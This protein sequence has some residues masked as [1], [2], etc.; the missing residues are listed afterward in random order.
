MTVDENRPD[1]S[2]SYAFRSHCLLFDTP[3]LYIQCWNCR[4]DDLFAPF[5]ILCSKVGCRCDITIQFNPVVFN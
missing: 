1:L 3:S 2:V 4:R 5:V